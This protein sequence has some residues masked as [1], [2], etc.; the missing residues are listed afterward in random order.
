[1]VQLSLGNRDGTLSTYI[2]RFQR[3]K[4]APAPRQAWAIVVFPMEA[5]VVGTQKI[6]GVMS[7]PFFE[8]AGSS[9][10]L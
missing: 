9:N 4:S 5:G 8:S 3:V 1:M 6:K 2:G 10:L 7:C